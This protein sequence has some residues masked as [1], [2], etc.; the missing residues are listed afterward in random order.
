[1]GNYTTATE[2]NLSV[3]ARRCELTIDNLSDTAKQIEK[4]F[5][6]GRRAVLRYISIR[7]VKE[8]LPD[9]GQNTQHYMGC[10]VGDVV[11]GI[12]Y[13]NGSI[14]A[15]QKAY[16]DTIALYLLPQKGIDACMGRILSA[17]QLILNMAAARHGEKK[18]AEQS[19]VQRI[20]DT[21]RGK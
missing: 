7:L 4:T 11:Y 13:A 8:I 14:N 20:I 12:C 19:F 1:M 17:E 10:A 16:T 15:V 5:G 21:A 3:W 2:Q 6:I 9:A 18:K